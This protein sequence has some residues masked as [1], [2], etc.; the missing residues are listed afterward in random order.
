M[1]SLLLASAM[2]GMMTAVTVADTK[3]RNPNIVIIISDDCGY[4]EFSM[5]GSKTMKTPRIDSIGAQGVRFTNGYVSGSVCSPSRA[6]LLTG[7]YQ[8]KFGHEFNIPPQYSETNGL[9]L[10]E[11]L[12]PAILRD[13]ASYRTIAIGKWHLGYAPQFHP[14]SRGFTDFYGFLQGARSYWPLDKPTRLNQLLRDRTPVSPEEFDYMTDELARESSACIKKF[15][16]EP[17]LLY[18]SFN[19]THGP[20]HATAS[21]LAAN[22][23]NK[24]AAMA[25]A[26]DRGVGMIL[27]TLEETG[28]TSETLLF[29]INDNGGAR[30][31]DNA[32][33]RGMKGQ[34]F[35]GGIR[36]PF[37]VQWPGRIPGG[38]VVDSPVIALDIVPTALAAAG[39]PLKNTKSP[40]LDGINLLPFM[41]TGFSETTELS[42]RMLYWKHGSAWAVRQGPYKLVLGSRDQNEGTPQL[43][44]LTND[45]AE[46][47]DI[48]RENQVLADRLNKAYLSWK[49][50]HQT[51][52]WAE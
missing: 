42:E 1:K 46:K 39:I 21:D 41:Q 31:H 15:R 29:F 11:T 8:Q 7:R 28:L 36:V 24:I 35:E 18:V 14:M 22:G 37:L 27:D 43:F 16:E 2:L 23:G 52:A 12:L 51:T 6:G 34:T 33:L 40:P 47:I 25:S 3:P 9:P 45:P 26:L 38:Q 32:P 48:A 30:G 50:G 20:N 44:N 13:E 49:S 4:N 17:F 5:H 10:S 19:A